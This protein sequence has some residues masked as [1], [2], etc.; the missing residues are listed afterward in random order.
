MREADRGVFII[1]SH[2]ADGRYPDG[3]TSQKLIACRRGR[4][5]INSK[6]KGVITWLVKGVF[7]LGGF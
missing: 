4:Q 5:R 7:G 2:T 6:F 3:A 1:F